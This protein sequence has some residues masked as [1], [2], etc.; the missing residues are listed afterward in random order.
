MA[1][2]NYI[3]AYVLHICILASAMHF[4]TNFCTVRYRTSHVRVF[5]PL[6]LQCCNRRFKLATSLEPSILPNVMVSSF[7]STFCSEIHKNAKNKTVYTMAKMEKCKSNANKIP[8]ASQK[9]KRC[10]TNCVFA[11]AIIAFASHCHTYEIHYVMANASV[12]VF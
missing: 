6:L 4:C 11:I 1:L 3:F 10:L 7:F 9:R 2:I 5:M 8:I 12:S